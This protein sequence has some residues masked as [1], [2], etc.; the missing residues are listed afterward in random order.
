MFMEVEV[1]SQTTRSANVQT[2]TPYQKL[3]S[4]A[5]TKKPENGVKRQGINLDLRPS[6]PLW[7]STIVQTITHRP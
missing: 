6:Y 2:F 4:L 7:Y 3:L 1:F 5:R